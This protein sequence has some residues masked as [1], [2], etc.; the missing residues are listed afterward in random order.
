MLIYFLFLLASLL[1]L[2]GMT[3]LGGA[4]KCVVTFFL[5]TLAFGIL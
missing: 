1:T 3:I 4:I 5:A 2:M